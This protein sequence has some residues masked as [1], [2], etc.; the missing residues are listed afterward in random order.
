VAYIN[1]HPKDHF[2]T[3]L[4][5]GNGSDANS[6]TG[7]GFKPDMVWTKNRDH[8]ADNYL[9]DIVRGVQN[10]IRPNV[11]TGTYATS[12]NLQSFDSDGFT[13]GTQDGLNKSGD[14]IVSW[15]W[16]LGG[17]QGSSNTD[18]SINTTYT[19][20]NTTSGVSCSTWNG[21]GSDGTIGTGLGA[22]PKMV[23]VK[24]LTS[25]SWWI[26]YH[27][28]LGN[29]K[30]IYLNQT[31]ASGSSTTWNTTTPTSSLISLDGG[32]GNG[33]NASGETYIGYAFA[34][35]K[36]FSA[37]GK[38]SGNGDSTYAPFIYTGFKPSLLILKN[39]SATESWYILDTK[40][41]G[42]NTNNYYLLANNSNTEGTSTSLATSLLSNG[43]RIENS[44]TSMNTSGQTYIY[45]AFAEE[46]LVSSNGVPAT[47]R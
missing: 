42:Y 44:D 39:T 27:A 33:V 38:F 15:N 4:Y 19:S 18:G 40:R 26:V 2:K 47:A 36:G 1:F 21:T 29:D 5:V 23:M 20:V 24:S 8:A 30:E 35:K 46:P 9:H 32:A 34:E 28:S 14:N 12:I 22:V 45:F 7:V 16:L 3:L 25:S 13:L 41:P 43:F 37:I 10:A 31:N 6:I 17:S 11:A